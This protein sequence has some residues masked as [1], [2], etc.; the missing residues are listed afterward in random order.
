[1]PDA[2][3]R[4]PRPRPRARSR[5]TASY[6]PDVRDGQPGGL[7]VE[8]PEG[9]ATPPRRS[10]TLTG[11][12]DGVRRLAGVLRRR[13]RPGRVVAPTLLDPLPTERDDPRPGRRRGLARPGREPAR[14]GH[15]AALRRRHGAR[16]GRHRRAD[17]DLRLAARPVAGPEPLLPLPPDRQRH[18][19]V[20]GPG[21][22]HGRGDRRPRAAAAIAAG[23]EIVT[24]AGRQRHPGRRRRRRGRPGTTGRATHTVVGPVRAGERRA[25]GAADPA[26]RAGGRRRPSRRAPSS[27]S[28]SCSTGCP[29]S[30]PASTRAVA[31]AGTLHLG[32]GL[33]ASSRRR[34]PTR[35]P[36]G[37]PR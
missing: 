32:R 28:T 34:T 10:A 35:R 15:R 27:R 3:H 23:A 12:D 24:G 17:R 4:G 36:A 19:R 8:R 16:R 37:C 30:G 22:R 11:A 33:H 25:V 2:A 7:L 18:R 1:M 31:F 21:R 20:A 26:G 14:R 5:T 13:R 29:G 9:E 6:T